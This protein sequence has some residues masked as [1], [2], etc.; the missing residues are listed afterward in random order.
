MW[1]VSHLAKLPSRKSVSTNVGTASPQSLFPC[2]FCSN[3]AICL[4]LSELPPLW[5]EEI[6]R[7]WTTLEEIQNVPLVGLEYFVEMTDSDETR[8]V[9][10]LCPDKR[11]IQA[12][13]VESHV[14]NPNHRAKYLGLH[15]PKVNVGLSYILKTTKLVQRNIY[16]TVMEKVCRAIESKYGR[17]YPKV[18]DKGTFMQ[19]KLQCLQMMLASSHFR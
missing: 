15:F 18:M 13:S 9:C 17:M 2:Q 12:S 4:G 10:L 5:K 16:F 7:I 6:P 1:E 14:T 11:P 8:Y 19:N 3:F